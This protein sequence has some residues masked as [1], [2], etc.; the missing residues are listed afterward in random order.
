MAITYQVSD[1]S[2]HLQS[3]NSSY[4][5]Q[6][7]KEDHLLHLYWGKKLPSF[8][9]AHLLKFFPAPSFTPGDTDFSLDTAPQEYP[10]YG[11]HDL[12]HP[13]LQLKNAGGDTICDLRYQSYRIFD[14][15][16]E[17]EGLPATYTDLP[18]QAQTLEIL[19]KDSV[20]NIEVALLYT[21]FAELD[22]IARSAKIVNHGSSAATMDKVMS[23]SVDFAGH[24][25]DFLH[26][27]GAWARERGVER[28][29]LF[30]G[31][32]SVDSARG[33]SSHAQ[34]PFI[35]LLSGNATETC[36][37]VYGFSLV[38]SGNFLA[39][40]AVEQYGSTRV[41]LGVNPFDFSWR[42]NP[43]EAFQTPE[44]LLVYSDN[45]LGG[46]SRTYHK[47]LRKH[48]VRGKFRDMPRPILINNWEATYFDFNAEKLKT[49]AEAA[50][51]VGIELFVLDDG[52]FGKRDA[53]NCSLG[54]W[55]VDQQKLPDGLGGLA[56]DINGKGLKFGLWVEPEMVSPD[57][58]LYRSHPDWCLH[59]KDRERTEARRQLILDYSREEVC[60]AV[61]QMLTRVFSSA[62]IQYVK[63]D[64]NRN[65]TE[66][67]SAALPPDRQRETAHRYIL[68]LYRML[69]RLTQKFPNIL[70]ESCSGGGGRFDPGMLYY[71]PQTWTSDDSD[72]IERLKIQY[73]TSMVYPAISM[74]AHV[75]AVPNHQVQRVTPLKTRGDVAMSGN[76]GYELDLTKLPEAEL[77][78]ISRQV[79]AYKKLRETVQFGD[80]YRLESPFSS[81]GA[82]WM[83]RSEDRRRVFVMKATV[84]AAANQANSRLKLQGLEDSAIYRCMETK[85]RYS[86]AELM[87]AGLIVPPAKHDFETWTWQFE[88]E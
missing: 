3:K 34:N 1:R 13:A 14:G 57:S 8:T 28:R 60:D 36:G 64:M 66:I 85:E 16:P 61:E 2:F 54:D 24:D 50:A 51:K 37:E 9:A 77:A 53:D 62:N 22:G 69:E 63:W 83:Y 48:L 29:P 35:A 71:M 87:Y 67:G 27:H 40:A 39:E 59:V 76:L 25:F 12:R 56:A 10:T 5:L 26:L 44:A 80:L 23:M 79:E 6:V 4:I 82:A 17:L 15:K 45:G 7:T 47:L 42:L 55:V 74:G 19:L 11:H 73:G 33:A 72:A 78:E 32:Q 31:T 58:E 46:M 43:G 49:L 52:W 68:G 70:F 84:L 38:Y 81:G 75:S 30:A 86:G 21:V 20:S 18:E 65:M 41:S 88:K